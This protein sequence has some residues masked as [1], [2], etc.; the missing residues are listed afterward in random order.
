M[1]AASPAC[2]QVFGLRSSATSL[3]HSDLCLA[4]VARLEAE[5]VSSRNE[6]AAASSPSPFDPAERDFVG[7]SSCSTICNSFEMQS[8]FMLVE[9]NSASFRKA[10]CKL[11]G[12]RTVTT[13]VSSVVS[14]WFLVRRRRSANIICISAYSV[15]RSNSA[16]CA[17]LS[18]A[19]FTAPSTPSTSR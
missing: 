13:R 18:N 4:L 11:S 16:R 10:R 6:S 15:V 8:L 1:R 14:C 12:K 3:Q 2:P 7:T 19:R 5:T 17:S 9:R